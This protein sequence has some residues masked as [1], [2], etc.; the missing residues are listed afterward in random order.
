MTIRILGGK[1][2]R[3]YL[4]TLFC[5]VHL[6][7]MVYHIKTNTSMEHLWN[8][9]NGGIS[10]YTQNILSRWNNVR[11]NPTRT[12]MGSRPVRRSDRPAT[13]TPESRL[14]R[15]SNSSVDF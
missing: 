10:K 4:T 5:Q 1:E 7:S 15:G 13:R 11:I 3:V 9:S 8:D 2:R 14:V 6:P 12:G